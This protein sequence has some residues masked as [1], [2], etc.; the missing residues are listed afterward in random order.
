MNG[1]GGCGQVPDLTRDWIV[2]LSIGNRMDGQ[3]GVLEDSG[4][5]FGRVG[6]EVT[7][8]DPGAG[9]KDGARSSDLD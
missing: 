4:F 9:V 5:V 7:V 6:F 2:I 8:G 3:F 1:D